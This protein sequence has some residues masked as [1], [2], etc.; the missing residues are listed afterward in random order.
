MRLKTLADFEEMVAPVPMPGIAAPTLPLLDQNILRMLVR[1]KYGQFAIP[2]ALAW[3][4]GYIRFFSKFDR[5]ETGVQQS[6]CYVTVRHGVP[7]DDADEWH[8]DGSSL[9]VELIPERN[10]IFTDKGFDFKTGRVS[11][12]PEFDPVRQNFFPYIMEALKDEPI[13]ESRGGWCRL[14]VNC[15]H[16]RRPTSEQHTFIRITFPDIEIRDV[17][18]TQNPLLPTEAFGRDPVAMFRNNLA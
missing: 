3:L 17:R 16:R 12:C 11:F 15:I 4:E 2:P 8:M 5:E 7:T 14:P 10:Y 6:W 13:Q 18:C 1:P 9:R